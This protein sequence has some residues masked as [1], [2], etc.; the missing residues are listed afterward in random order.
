MRFDY[1]Y[2]QISV[3]HPSR[4]VMLSGNYSHQTMTRGFTELELMKDPLNREKIAAYMALEEEIAG[5]QT[6]E[7]RE[8]N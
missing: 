1:A 8:G 5:K 2:V 4:Q 6:K 3:C 7:W